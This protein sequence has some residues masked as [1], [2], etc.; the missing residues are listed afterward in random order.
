MLCAIVP[1]LV[2]CIDLL[3]ACEWTKNVKNVL[4]QVKKRQIKICP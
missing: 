1:R 2:N 4:R 3:M